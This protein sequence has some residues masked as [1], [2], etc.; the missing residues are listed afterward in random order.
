MIME[1]YFIQSIIMIIDD[2]FVQ[3]LSWL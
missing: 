1:D 2:Y 3:S